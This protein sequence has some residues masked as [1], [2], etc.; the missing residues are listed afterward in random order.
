MGAQDSL[1]A[2]SIVDLGLIKLN[3]KNSV[4][5]FSS[6]ISWWIVLSRRMGQNGNIASHSSLDVKNHW[7]TKMLRR[8]SLRYCGNGKKKEKRKE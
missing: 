2:R 3:K 6:R 4:A 1:A 8:L 7:S 5:L